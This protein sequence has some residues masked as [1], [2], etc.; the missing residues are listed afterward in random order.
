MAEES[1]HPALAMLRQL[2][3]RLDGLAEELTRVKGRLAYVESRLARLETECA[4]LTAPQVQQ[5]LGQ[6]SL[7]HAE[8]APPLSPGHDQD[9]LAELARKIRA[10]RTCIYVL[11]D[12]E[13]AALDAA[14]QAG[15]VS[16]DEVMAFWRRRGIG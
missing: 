10:R 3:A 7:D 4:A 6:M 9:E 11:S 15:I 8:T 1:E 13:R 16:H 5:V 12:D 14:L 2:E